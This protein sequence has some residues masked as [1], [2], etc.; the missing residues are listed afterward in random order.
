MVS[1]ETPGHLRILPWSKKHARKLLKDP[2]ST[3]QQ[4]RLYSKLVA[5]PEFYPKNEQTKVAKFGSGIAFMI[6]AENYFTIIDGYPLN[7][8]G[9]PK[10]HSV[11]SESSPI[12][13][14]LIGGRKGQTKSFTHEGTGKKITL[15]I[16]KIVGPIEAKKMFKG[17]SFLTDSTAEKELPMIMKEDTADLALQ[18]EESGAAV[19]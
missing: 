12:G 1:H 9:L 11:S 7:G 17:K 3:E 2:N 14:A 15:I 8:D 4:K 5:A 19:A 13:K 16:S 18:T 6:G 10:N